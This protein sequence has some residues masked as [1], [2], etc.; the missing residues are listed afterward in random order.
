MN[1]TELFTFVE[2]NLITNEAVTWRFTS[3]DAQVIFEGE[4]YEPSA[5]G[6]TTEIQNKAEM[7]RMNLALSV[8][9]DHI[10]ARRW[11]HDRIVNM[12]SLTIHE[13]DI[14][15]DMNVIWKGRLVGVNPSTTVVKLNFESIYTSLRRAGLG[16]S[17]QRMCTH[18]LYGPK[19]KVDK[20]LYRH[21]A[22]VTN[23]TGSVVISPEASAFENGYF[24]GGMLL[25]SD[26]H[27][28]LIV[29]HNASSL[30]LLHDASGIYADPAAVYYLF[31]GCPRNR[32]TCNDRFSNIANYGGFDW[33]PIRNPM[34][35]NSIV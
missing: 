21:A 17:F 33:I 5:I 16:T 13:R 20:E 2:T 10:L 19:C 32:Q 11:A 25:S 35:G 29:L 30:T 23:V 24:T 14:E 4:P 18:M 27:A 7:S 22:T 12:V 8:S 31:P 26:G 1:V 6:R 15:G 28:K 3:G 34:D 9:L